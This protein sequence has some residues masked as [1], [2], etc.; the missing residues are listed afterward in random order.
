MLT[1][2]GADF[3]SKKELESILEREKRELKEFINNIDIKRSETVPKQHTI[4]S[5]SPAFQYDEINQINLSIKEI[6]E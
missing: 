3:V 2:L 5:T 1:N 6:K 4:D